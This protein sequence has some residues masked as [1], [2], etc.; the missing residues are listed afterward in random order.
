MLGCNLKQSFSWE[1]E[2]SKMQLA[3]FIAISE[4]LQFLFQGKGINVFNTVNLG[5]LEGSSLNVSFP[6][7][8]SIQNIN[9]RQLFDILLLTAPGAP[10]GTSGLPLCSK[11]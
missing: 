5:K 6:I 8:L 11:A 1:A 4:R 2:C 9:V 10:C 7:K 3:S